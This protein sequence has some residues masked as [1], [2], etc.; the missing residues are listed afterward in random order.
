MLIR[1]V[2]ALILDENPLFIFRWSF[3]CFFKRLYGFIKLY[4]LY[5]AIEFAS[6]KG[7]FV[8]STVQNVKRKTDRLENYNS[9]LQFCL[10]LKYSVASIF[11]SATRTRITHIH[12]IFMLY[13]TLSISSS[14][15][16]TIRMPLHLPK[17]N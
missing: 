6:S 16:W 1:G 10:R 17:F 14:S 3:V 4:N 5:F 11:P 2:I 12:C 7:I 15:F 8:V 13:R 9:S